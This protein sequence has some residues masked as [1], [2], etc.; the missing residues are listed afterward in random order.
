MIGE[1]SGI[2]KS[3]KA[4]AAVTAYTVAKFGTDDE[5][6]I[7]AAA[8]TDLLAGIFQ[9]NA[10]SGAE[11]RVMLTGIGR[12]KLGTGGITRGAPVTVD[13]SGQGIALSG[14]AGTNV[15]SIGIAMASGVAGDIVPVLIVPSRPQQ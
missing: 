14:A 10:A 7:P 6:M 5:T 9:H 13:A 15:Q 2:E 3:I 12:L 11:V 8:N 4:G 1:T